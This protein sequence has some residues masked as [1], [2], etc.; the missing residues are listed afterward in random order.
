MLWLV[1]IDGIAESLI[2][3][4]KSG[5]FAYWLGETPWGRC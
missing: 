1:F 5:P 4:Y 2:N 3:G